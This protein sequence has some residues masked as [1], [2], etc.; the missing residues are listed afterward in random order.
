MLRPK[1]SSGLPAGVDLKPKTG[2]AGVGERAVEV[3]PLVPRPV[4]ADR[5]HRQGARPVREV[6]LPGRLLGVRGA[7]VVGKLPLPLLHCPVGAVRRLARGD[8]PRERRPVVGAATVAECL[9]GLGVRL[10]PAAGVVEPKRNLRARMSRSDRVDRIPGEH[11]LDL[12]S[13]RVRDQRLALPVDGEPHVVGI[14]I[15]QLRSVRSGREH[16]GQSNRE[17][18][19]GHTATR[20]SS[21]GK[22]LPSLCRRSRWGSRSLARVPSFEARPVSVSRL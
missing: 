19:T 5:Q 10:A 8:L 4:G 21:S 12:P 3:V 1:L 20:L 14:S 13:G 7:A 9:P 16:A 11:V 2:C 15:D 17:Q 18:R 22:R 6:H